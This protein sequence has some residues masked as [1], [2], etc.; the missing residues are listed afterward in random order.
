MAE[1]STRWIPID[2]S[3]V[4]AF[5]N[6][7]TTSGTLRLTPLSHDIPD[8][9]RGSYDNEEA[10]LR[11]SFRYNAAEQLVAIVLSEYF[12]VRLGKVTG[13]LF[14]IE[15]KLNELE[16]AS[17]QGSS[18]SRLNHA[19]QEFRDYLKT[20]PPNDRRRPKRN[21][22]LNYEVLRQELS[23]QAKPLVAEA[24]AAY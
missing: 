20:L 23:K 19:M 10:L 15:I 5:E 7:N 3:K 6:V 1:H 16:K 13:R 18:E 4:T 2:R 12:T 14:E 17:P 21:A 8:M 9:V 22:T 24:I 11:I